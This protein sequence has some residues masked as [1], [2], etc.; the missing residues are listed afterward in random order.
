MIVTFTIRLMLPNDGLRDIV[1]L[2]ARDEFR[3]SSSDI[4]Y[5]LGIVRS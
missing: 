5:A 3:M 1:Q 2:R 4:K